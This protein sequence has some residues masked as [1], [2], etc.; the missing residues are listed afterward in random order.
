[1]ARI[2]RFGDR[3]A[4]VEVAERPGPEATETI[5]RLFRVLSERPFPGMV[6]AV[7]ALTTLAVFYDP[8]AVAAALR[9]GVDAA[10]GVD[11]ESTPVFIRVRAELERAIGEAGRGGT[12]GAAEADGPKEDEHV[13]VVPV[14]YGGEF[15]PDLAELAER[16]GMTPE[17]AA[18]L[19]SAAEYRV[20]MIGFLPGFPYLTGLPE[21]LA[22]PRKETPRSRVPPGA[23]GIGGVYTGIYPVASP[24]GWRWIGRTPLS[25]F[26]PDRTP[27]F[28][29]RVGDRVRFRPISEEE[30]RAA[31]ESP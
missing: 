18:A 16:S 23:V 10:P 3:A 19:H 8:V 5:A 7:P 20:A 12:V 22:A 11:A 15:G 9:G 26:D 1:M 4:V 27:P 6:E 30:F 21:R 25:L 24:G 17:E 13:V 31:G 14:C 2:Y 29:L 28:L